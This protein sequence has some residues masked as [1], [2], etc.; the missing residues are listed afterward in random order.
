MVGDILNEIRATGF[1]LK[2]AIMLPPVLERERRLVTIRLITDVTFVNADKMRALAVVKKYV[3]SYFGCAVEIS[4]LSPDCEM[5]KHKIL[6]AVCAC[7]KPVFAVI[8]EKDISVTKTADGFSYQINVPASLCNDGLC[9]K[10]N[11]YMRNC[12]CGN[13]SGKCVSSDVNLT[14]LEVEE[15]PDEIEYEI[16]V[17][18]FD[19]ADF[20]PIESERVLKKAVYISDLNFPSEEVVVC[21]TIDSLNER[22][23][24]NK[25]GQEKS[26]LSLVIND[27]T[28]AMHATYFMRMKSADKIKQLKVGDSIV[29]T[30][31]NEEYNGSLRFTAKFIDYGKTPEGFVPEKRPSKPVPSYYHFVE[32]QPYSD[33]EQ[34][35]FLNIKET[36][37]CL[38]GK[39]FVVLDLETTGLNSS[40]V[41]GNMDKI[42]EIGAFKIIDGEIRESFT[43]F[44]NP[45]RKL[46]EEIVNLT[47]ITPDMV[48][49]APTSD[50]VMPDFYKFCYGSVLVGHNIVGFDYR[51]IDY[52][53]S[54]LG[55]MF[56]RK[57]MDTIS[58]SQELLFLSNYKLNT[59]ADRFN[60]TFNHHRAIDDALATAK[61]FIELIRMK[62]SLPKIQ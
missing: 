17:R 15:T 1:N 30:G 36:P 57:L 34:V 23:Y 12:Y 59:V 46:S 43:T 42:I 48:E 2:N 22:T 55:Y 40:P 14:E 7:S 35:D 50:Q 16:P 21:G 10:I 6:S 60:I 5:V 4:K 33:I 47:G 37:E 9:D 18:Y 11:D 41:S 49:N 58:L 53:W 31:A 56:D 62:K 51:F 24:T 26:Y 29:C 3:P 8:T 28:G 27:G 38:K 32:P 20:Q 13:F 61:I 52:Y 45:E 39:T 54:K 25:K 44:I 19:I